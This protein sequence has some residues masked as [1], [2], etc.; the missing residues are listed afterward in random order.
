MDAEE[1]RAE[2][3]FPL[4]DTVAVA[5]GLAVAGDDPDFGVAGFDIEDIL[6]TRYTNVPSAG[7]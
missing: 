2:E 7:A 6:P 3:V 4:G 5:V 1:G